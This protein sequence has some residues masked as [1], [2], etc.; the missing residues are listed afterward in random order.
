MTR[1]NM[2]IKTTESIKFEKPSFEGKHL[3]T[4]EGGQ[5]IQKIWRFKNGYGASVVQLKLF[6]GI[7]GSYTDNE[8]EW[9]FAVLKFDK[10]G[11]YSLCYDS[12]IT[13][14]V[15]GH[16]TKEE[17]ENLLKRIKENEEK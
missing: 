14:D 6:N 12:G 7:W 5:R 13:A 1:Q 8:N 3:I 15:I 9:E 16:L 17:V 2:K 4:R 10:T 11:N